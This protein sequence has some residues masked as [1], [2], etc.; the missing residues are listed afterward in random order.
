MSRTKARPVQPAVFKPTAGRLGYARA[1][2][3]AVVVMVRVAVPST[4]SAPFVDSPSHSA[5]HIATP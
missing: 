1:P 5:Y 2:L 4:N 3:V